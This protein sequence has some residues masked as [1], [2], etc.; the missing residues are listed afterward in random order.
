MTRRDLAVPGRI[1]VA[2]RPHGDDQ[3]VARYAGELAHSLGA[4]LILL[5]VSAVMPVPTGPMPLVE[6]LDLEAQR[7][8]QELVDRMAREDL[9][10]IAATLAP[11]L[12]TESV[13]TWG[14]PG[15][16]T[17]DAAREH[18]ADLVV[19]PMQERDHALGHVL[20]D[21]EDRHVLHHCHVPVL[22]VPTTS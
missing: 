2:I 18:H 22:V 12:S 19:V 9:E 16:A 14:S 6:P 20:H 8:E 4:T 17:V 7:G 21:H 13:L 15:P 1:L 3:A 10:E 5:G 11:G